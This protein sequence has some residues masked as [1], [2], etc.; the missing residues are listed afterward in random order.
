M[1]VPVPLVIFGFRRRVLGRERKRE[2][3]RED[4]CGVKS[5]SHFFGSTGGFAPEV[6]FSSV[7]IAFLATF[8][9]CP[10]ADSRGGLPS[11]ASCLVY[12]STP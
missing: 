8:S 9:L 11:N 5:E 12:A 1:V 10:I 6:A 4:D 2:R 7:S 3:K